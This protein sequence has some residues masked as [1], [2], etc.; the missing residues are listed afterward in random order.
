MRIWVQPSARARRAP[1][2]PASAKVASSTTAGRQPPLGDGRG[3]LDDGTNVHAKTWLGLGTCLPLDRLRSPGSVVE[4]VTASIS[5]YPVGPGT[6]VRR[7]TFAVAQ[8][9]PGVGHVDDFT[10]LAEVRVVALV[11]AAREVGLTGRRNEEKPRPRS[12]GGTANSEPVLAHAERQVAPVAVG[13]RS[14]HGAMVSPGP[15]AADAHARAVRQE[16][17]NSSS[18]TPPHTA[19]RLAP[20]QPL[21]ASG[22]LLIKGQ[23][24]RPKTG[25]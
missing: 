18:T 11:M 16:T 15:L 24:S 12:F 9:C 1:G 21:N 13:R 8:A 2:R 19:N 10:P 23:W 6:T 3:D 7:D 20:F 5:G 14:C 25:G 4:A 22:P 17:R